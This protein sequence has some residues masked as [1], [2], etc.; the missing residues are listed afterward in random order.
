MDYVLPH[1]QELIERSAMEARPVFGIC[2]GHQL[3]ARAMG[4]PTYR[5]KFGNR[6]GNHPV[7]ELESGRAHITSQNHS[8]AVAIDEGPAGRP[9]AAVDGRE[10]APLSATDRPREPY[11]HPLN[12]N[13]LI[14]HVNINDSSNEGIALVHKPVFSV[15]YHPEGCPGP[16][17][18]TYL[19]DRFCEM[20]AMS[21]SA[22]KYFA[23]GI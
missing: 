19:F 15:Q 12:D 7:L 5:L 22:P 11:L 2:L 16:K 20:M 9:A 1:L 3:I 8:Y 17:D 21:G 13:V 4:L 18:N 14:T 10:R 23:A 6:G